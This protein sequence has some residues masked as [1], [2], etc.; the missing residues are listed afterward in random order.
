MDSLDFLPLL[1]LYLYPQGKKIVDLFSH[2]YLSKPKYKFFEPFLQKEYKGTY[3]YYFFDWEKETRTKR[4]TKTKNQHE[5]LKE[6]DRFKKNYFKGVKSENIK[7]I[8]ELR[9]MILH[10]YKHTFT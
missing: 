8:M 5:A 9:D 3:Y 4:T 2:N 10:Y 1:L 6:F 7:N